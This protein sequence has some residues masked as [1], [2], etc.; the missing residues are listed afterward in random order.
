MEWKKIVAIIRTEDKLGDVETRLKKI[1][2]R[3]ISVTRGK[4]YGE[5]AN[6]FRS[7]WSAAHARLEIYC[8]LARTE[9][10]V[11]AIMDAAQTGLPGDGIVAVIPVEKVYRIRTRTQGNGD[12]GLQP[13]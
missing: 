2:V 7:D 6:F 3:G 1:H 10:I 5:Y 11:D 12:N 8:R 9:E 4:G 13:A